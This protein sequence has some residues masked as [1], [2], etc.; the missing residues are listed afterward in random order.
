MELFPDNDLPTQPYGHAIEDSHFEEYDEMSRLKNWHDEDLPTRLPDM[1][2]EA[3]LWVVFDQL[4]DAYTMLG[5]ERTD[6]SATA[7]EDKENVR[8]SQQ[9]WDEIIHRDGHLLNI[10]LKSTDGAQGIPFDADISKE[11]RSHR[12]NRFIQDSVSITEPLT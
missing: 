1:I 6:I 7:T 2:P 9:P 12:F 3:F 4:I 5:T 11:T 8:E 10:F